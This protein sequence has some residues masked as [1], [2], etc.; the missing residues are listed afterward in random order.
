MRFCLRC[1]MI[2]RF[3][4]T[5]FR[6]HEI[7]LTTKRWNEA[8]NVDREANRDIMPEANILRSS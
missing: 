7:A 6:G 3:N 5:N 4:W 2:A 8:H 1:K